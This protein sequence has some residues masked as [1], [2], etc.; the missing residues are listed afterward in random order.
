MNEHNLT[1]PS[2]HYSAFLTFHA[3]ARG[4]GKGSAH[5]GPAGLALEIE[6]RE[7]VLLCFI[8]VSHAFELP[9]THLEHS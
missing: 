5:W 3:G 2:R 6:W 9:Q 1:Q 7:E 8:C 4:R